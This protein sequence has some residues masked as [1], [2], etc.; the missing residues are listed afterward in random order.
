MIA[1]ACSMAQILDGAFD[2]N[3]L[4]LP[5]EIINGFQSRCK[6]LDTVDALPYPGCRMCDSPCQFRFD[7]A[8]TGPAFAKEFQRAFLD[9]NLKADRLIEIARNA[10][11][12]SFFV[13]DRDSMVGASFCF[14]VQQFA[15]ADL[16]LAMYY[17][18]EVAAMM[19]RRL[20]ARK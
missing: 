17:Q 13:S 1:S 7:M 11:A 10:A 8:Q 19:K 3:H 16:G 18:H 6:K 20:T 14:A 15:V 4:V 2:G 12:K 9:V 5:P